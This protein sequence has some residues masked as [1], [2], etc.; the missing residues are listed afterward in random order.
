MSRSSNG[1][2]DGVRAMISDDFSA[3][4][5]QLASGAYVSLGWPCTHQVTDSERRMLRMGSQGQRLGGYGST[6]IHDRLQQP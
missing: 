4:F 1:G 6:L 2:G 3:S 5:W